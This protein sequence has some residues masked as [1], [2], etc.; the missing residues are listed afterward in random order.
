MIHGKH[1]ALSEVYCLIPETYQIVTTIRNPYDRLVSLYSFRK[2][3]FLS[4]EH[5]Q[6]EERLRKAYELGFKDWLLN[7]L[8]PHYSAGNPMDQPLSRLLLVDGK[9]P[10]NVIVMKL[11]TLQPEVDLFLLRL[12]IRTDLRLPKLNSSGRR[13]YM[14]YYDEELLFTVYEWDRYIFDNYYSET[15][16]TGVPGTVYT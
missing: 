10:Q 2:K 14:T 7:D 5:G 9:V 3:R 12:Q 16:E 8:M 4:G 11:E 1:N 15:K 6:A 13:D